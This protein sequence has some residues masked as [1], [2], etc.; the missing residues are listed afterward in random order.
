MVLVVP[1][2][3]GCKSDVWKEHYSGIEDNLLDLQEHRLSTVLDLQ[4]DRKGSVSAEEKQ[5]L[6]TLYNKWCEQLSPRPAQAG[7][8]VPKRQKMSPEEAKV[9]LLLS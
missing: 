8:S 2:V 9:C 1:R 6:R 5:Y 3:P 7:A 4:G